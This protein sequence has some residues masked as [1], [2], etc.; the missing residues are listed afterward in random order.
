MSYFRRL[1]PYLLIM[2]S[3]MVSLLFFVVPLVFLVIMSFTEGS[4]FFFKPIVTFGNYRTVFTSYLI[5]IRNTVL[6]ASVAA[7]ID[8]LIGYPYAYF[9]VRRVRKFGDLFRSILLFPLLGELYIAYGF[10]W[11]FLPGG[12]LAFIL[13]AFGISPFAL[14]YSP[15]A[16]TLALAVYTLPFTILQIGISL[17]QIDPV[18]EE[19]AN[20]LGSGPLRRL[21]YILLPLS[22]P[23]IL[24]GWLI[25]F[26]WNIGAYAIPFLMG[27]AIVGQR[28]LSVQIRAVGLLMMNFGL[29]A[30][31]ATILVV[32]STTL[33]YISFKISKGVMV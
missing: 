12:P 24:S 5:D 14:L 10:W 28:V 17:S 11:L 31:L 27:G 26:G 1:L 15:L 7:T 30:A 3:F 9:M 2:P 29:A 21:I 25:S 18:Y 16:A 33:T 6:L 19:S 13:E 22:L 23:G 4:S 8:V 32:M 20:C